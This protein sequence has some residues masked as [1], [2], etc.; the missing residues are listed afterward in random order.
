MRGMGYFRGSRVIKRSVVR[1]GRR[2]GG[3]VGFCLENWNSVD[4][5]FFFKT[6]IY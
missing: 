5:F 1:K 2:R 6:F 3:E 4:N